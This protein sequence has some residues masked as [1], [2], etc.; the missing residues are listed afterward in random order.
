MQPCSIIAAQHSCCSSAVFLQHNYGARYSCCSV[1]QLL[2]L[3]VSL[4]NDSTRNSAFACYA[5]QFLHTGCSDAL[6]AQCRVLDWLQTTSVISI[7]SRRTGVRAFL[8]DAAA[9]QEIGVEQSEL[10]CLRLLHRRARVREPVHVGRAG[11]A[12]RGLLRASRNQ[13]AL[14]CRSGSVVHSHSAA[15]LRCLLSDFCLC[16]RKHS[17]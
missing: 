16:C 5:Q 6:Q 17:K 13:A 2:A 8:S 14:T 11:A 4:N 3:S 7:T 12:L 1:L 9:H 10:D 15:V